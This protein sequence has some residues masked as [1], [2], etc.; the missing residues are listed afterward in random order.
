ME[1]SYVKTVFKLLK[2]LGLIFAIIVVAN[3]YV[4]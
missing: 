4:K 1:K 3:L 2:V